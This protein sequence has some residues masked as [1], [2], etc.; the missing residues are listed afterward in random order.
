MRRR[1]RAP[2]CEEYSRTLLTQPTDGAHTM[3]RHV[4]GCNRKQELF[5]LSVAPT[6]GVGHR[7]EQPTSQPRFRQSYLGNSADLWDPLPTL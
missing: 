3:R 7:A 4:T 6:P 1:L 2:G 5:S